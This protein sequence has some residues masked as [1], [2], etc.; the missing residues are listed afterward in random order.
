MKWF[1]QEKY[2]CEPC[3]HI[4]HNNHKNRLFVSLGGELST[5]TGMTKYFIGLV[6]RGMR[7]SI[8]GGTRCCC[9]EITECKLSNIDSSS[10]SSHPVKWILSGLLAIVVFYYF[11][12][13]PIDD[14]ISAIRDPNTFTIDN[15]LSLIWSAFR[16][17]FLYQ[18]LRS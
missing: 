9:N 18:I 11:L 8:A 4:C 17:W 6:A 13:D 10:N 12:K 1:E 15:I 14:T 2:V 3:I 16:L 7:N 5:T